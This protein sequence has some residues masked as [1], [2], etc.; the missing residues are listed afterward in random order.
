MKQIKVLDCTL[1]DGGYYNNWDFNENLARESVAA[2]NKSGIDIIEIGYKSLAKGQFYG[3]FKYCTESQLEFLKDNK[4]VEYAFML[5]A[6]EFVQNDKLDVIALKKCVKP[7]RD[8]LFSWC[9]V[10]TYYNTIHQASE[11]VKILNE[12]GYRTTINL[13]AMSLLSEDE[14]IDALQIISETPL[15]V[16][17]FADSF[18]S[19]KP[20]DIFSY[21]QLIRKY[22]QGP[23]GLHT[24][25]NQGL[26]FANT[27]AAIEAGVE[28]ID[29]TFTGMGRGAGNLKL[30]QL[31]LHLYFKLNREDLNPFALLDVINNYFIPLQNYY[32]WGWDFNYMLSGIKNIHPTYCQKLKSNNQYTLPQMANILSN[33]PAQSRSKYN[34][35]E[36][37]KISDSVV[38]ISKN[39]VNP[40]GLQPSIQRSPA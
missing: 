4:D 32:G 1:R 34:E 35:K 15:D 2:L 25:D 9:R 14:F 33:I 40:I 18:G 37:I 10:A 11:I 29:G 31:L 13:M 6:K 28:Y 39:G 24:H 22:Y 26:A 20:S 7:K 5:D 21:V 19:F 17:Y 36:L 3:L 38:N 23:I 8:S 12:M 27:L 16:F 30:E